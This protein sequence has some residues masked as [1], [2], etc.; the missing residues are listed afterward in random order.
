MIDAHH[1][2]WDLQAVHYPWLMEKG[3]RRFFG[4]PSP[5]QRDYLLP[6]FRSAAASLGFTGSVHIQ[7][8]AA[9]GLA[10]ARWVDQQAQAN[11]DW[12]LA[13]VVYCDLSDPELASQLDHFQQLDS[14]RGVRQ[15]IA[16]AAAED[17]KSGTRQLLRSPAF[18]EGLHEIGHRGL[19]FD[20]QLVP[21]VMEETARLLQEVPETP[22]ALCHAGS[23]EDRS[24]TG[25]ARWADQLAALSGLPQILCKL[26]GL[27]MFQPDWREADFRPI[28]ETCLDQFGPARC[29]F[30]SNFPV[31]SLYSDYAR[32]VQAHQAL[33][34]EEWHQAVFLENAA[35]FYRLDI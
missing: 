30:G 29:A 7:V 4:D 5:I 17:A 6:E 22:V 24:K 2:L 11:P 35:R 33:V 3:V 34:P 8:G 27:G 32:L 28:I 10:E 14:V 16:R 21:E 26:S 20:L 25:L 13:Q 15:I 18:K 1:H 31:D 12:P 19:S 9:D 23:P